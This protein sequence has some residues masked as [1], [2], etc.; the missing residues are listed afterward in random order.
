MGYRVKKEYA[1]KAVLVATIGNEPVNLLGFDVKK[2][3]AATAKTIEKTVI[4]KGATQ[5]D[6]KEFFEAGN[7]HIEYFDEPKT[8]TAKVAAS[9]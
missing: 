5:S 1:K 8:A 9:E 2:I 4:I 3:V 6:L 7:V